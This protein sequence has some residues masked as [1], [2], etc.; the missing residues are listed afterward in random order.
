[1][2]EI[3]AVNEGAMIYE[4]ESQFFHLCQHAIAGFEGEDFVDSRWSWLMLTHA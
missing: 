2:P 3:S 4:M 1:V